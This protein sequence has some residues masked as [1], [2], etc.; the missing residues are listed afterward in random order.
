MN[1]LIMPGEK[2]NIK[3]HVRSGVK[4]PSQYQ[5]VFH[6]DD[7][8]PMEFVTW[9][10]MHIFFKS[11]EEALNMMLKVHHEGSATVGTYSYDIATSK[12]NLTVHM[13]RKSGY[14]LRLSVVKI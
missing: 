4:E 2:A 10:L 11:E 7:F 8:T 1:F 6:N 12:A 14:P 9:V 5:V 3:E 13:A